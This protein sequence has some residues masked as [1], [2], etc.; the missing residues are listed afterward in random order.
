MTG[1]ATETFRT[2][3]NYIRAFACLWGWR[4]P[5]DDSRAVLS[6]VATMTRR[7]PSLTVLSCSPCDR[8]AVRASLINCWGTEL[9]LALAGAYGLQDEIVRLSNNWAVVQLYYAMQ[10][11]AQALI[12][13]KGGLRPVSHEKT[14]RQFLTLW[15]DH[16]GAQSLTPL[17]LA[18]GAGGPRNV[19]GSMCADDRIHEWT[20]CNQQTCWSLA[21][22]ALRT[23]RAD[24]L[25]ERIDSHRKSKLKA[26]KDAWQK[27]QDHRLAQ[28]KRPTQEPQWRRPT[29]SATEKREVNGKLRDYSMIDYFYRLR[30]RSNYQ[31]ASMFSDGP[32]D[33]VVSSRVH[34]DL[35][36][37]AQCT[38]L[39]HK[40][41]VMEIVGV[42]TF[43][44]WADEWLRT[45][46]TSPVALGL[47]AR[48]GL[49]QP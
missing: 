20:T 21:L 2:H 16:S 24:P 37:I 3:S 9:L 27:Q 44:G 30:A 43:L 15:V 38:L 19:P 1:G 47:R 39:V 45:T 14:K 10:H 13:A 8:A 35:V 17:S 25:A 23:T 7:A 42:S 6:R 29:L 49:M 36:S 34:G 48:R 4:R 46:Y 12:V 11:A 28:R 26:K 40:L 5:D 33:D 41:H 32:E 31:D 18:Y 22:K